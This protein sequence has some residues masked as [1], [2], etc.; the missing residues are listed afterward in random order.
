MIVDAEPISIAIES[1]TRFCKAP[2]PRN[3]AVFRMNAIAR[4]DNGSS[5]HLV[6]LQIGIYTI[7]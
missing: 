4:H 7:T 1:E 6:I 2:T 3:A 5:G